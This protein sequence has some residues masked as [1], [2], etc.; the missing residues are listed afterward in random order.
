VGREQRCAIGADADKRRLRE[1]D[2]AGVAEREVQPDRG[3]G[4]HRPQAQQVDAV[5]LEAER[6]RD[7]QYSR[8]Q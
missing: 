7:Q 8:R 3:N 5:G 4:H 2:L 6:G 1:R